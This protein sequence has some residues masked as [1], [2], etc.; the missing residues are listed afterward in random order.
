MLHRQHEIPDEDLVGAERR[1]AGARR[2]AARRQQPVVDASPT[3]RACRSSG[4]SER[5][6]ATASASIAAGAPRLAAERAAKAEEIR[7]ERQQPR[8]CRAFP[9][10]RAAP[11]FR[12]SAWHAPDESRHALRRHMVEQ[13]ALCLVGR[14]D[15]RRHGSRCLRE[16]R[17][18]GRNPAPGRR[19][20]RRPALC[21]PGERRQRAGAGGRLRRREEADLDVVRRRSPRSPRPW[22]GSSRDASAGR[23]RPR[24]SRRGVPARPITRPADGIRR[25]RAR[26]RRPWG[27]SGR[28]CRRRRKSRSRLR[29]RR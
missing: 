25:H 2:I 26:A 12:P 24:W 16:H 28:R 15:H 13:P 6:A 18:A 22:C 17:P 5:I 1:I 29:R 11:T 27:P 4:I 8:E 3:G 7:R 10:S 19:T 23:R 21:A 20:A 14:I 9:A